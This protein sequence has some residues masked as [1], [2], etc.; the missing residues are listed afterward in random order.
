M[1]KLFNHLDTDLVSL[2][3]L[4]LE[5]SRSLREQLTEDI[6]AECWCSLIDGAVMTVTVNDSNC[7]SLIHY[8]QREL[9]KCI[10][11]EFKDRLNNPLRQI[12][13]QI[14]AHHKGHN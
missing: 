10:N 1:E 11:A 3:R 7:A 2:L 9:L 8:Q 12:K 6:G 5:I 4:Q 13:V 14:A